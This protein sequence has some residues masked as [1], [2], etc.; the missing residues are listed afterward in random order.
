MDYRKEIDGL[1]AIAVLA[2]I[3]DHTGLGWLPGGYA[4]VDVFFVISGFLITGIVQKGLADG[5]FTFRDF[6]K[7]RAFR[8]FPA[9]FFVLAVTT[10][11][12]WIFL[13]P[14]ELQDFSA[15]VFFSVLFLS[16]GFFINFVDYFG[17]SA[18]VIPLLHTWSLAVEEQFYILF[19]LLAWASWKLGGKRGLL[20]TVVGLGLASLL[21]AEWGWRNEPTANYFF[22]PS[23][24]WEILLGSVAALALAGRKRPENGSLAAVGLLMLAATF[25]LYDDLVPF[26]SVYAL[27]PTLGTVLIL[28]FAP[29]QGGVSAVLSGSVMRWI[30]GISFSAYLWH[31]PVFAFSRIRGL[32][33]DQLGIAIV[34]IAFVLGL[35]YGSWRLIEQPFRHP[36]EGR[37]MLRKFRGMILTVTAAALIAISLAGYLSDVPLKRHSAADQNLFATTRVEASSYNR[38]IRKGFQ[39]QAFVG[40]GDA[41]KVAMVGDSFGRDVMNALQ[42]NGMMAQLDFALW[43]IGHTCAPFFL[44]DE[45]GLSE[46]VDIEACDAEWDRYQSEAMLRSLVQADVIIVSHKWSEWQVPF[47]EKTLENLAEHSG[48][49][50]ILVGPKQ[51]GF[52]D[53]REVWVI[54][55]GMRSTTELD[56][57]DEV[58]A[59]NTKMRALKAAAYFDIQSSVCPATKTCPA[60]TPEGRAISLDGG[61]LTP[62]AARLV[63]ERLWDNS[64]IVEILGVSRP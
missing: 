10:L 14:S 1:R 54:E 45:T 41:T 6:Y 52:S 50:V 21:L 48:A 5:S 63:G 16:N 35:S 34:L 8:I 44:K 30:G 46:H 22:S 29:A 31:Q 56:V 28:V 60:T 43:T 47:V 39:R 64:D 61:H 51:F 40:S 53:L 42:E 62:A 36:A 17:P 2:V 59:T 25:V 24:F 38:G 20:W 18:S 23:R 12:A 57:S 3:I 55:E 32:A 37:P 58:V 9:L 33:P 26:P 13:T 11:Y 15:S 19:P 49:N 27:L 7:R 4:G